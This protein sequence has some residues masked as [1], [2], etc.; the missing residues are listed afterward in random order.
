M[1]RARVSTLPDWR[2]MKFWEKRQKIRKSSK[3]FA[4]NIP[5]PFLL[6]TEQLRNLLPPGDGRQEPDRVRPDQ[7]L[8]RGDHGQLDARR[9]PVGLLLLVRV[10]DVG[11]VLGLVVAVVVLGGAVEARGLWGDVKG[12]R[13]VECKK[14]SLSQYSMY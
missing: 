6:P 12:S 13:L 9:L 10:R 7:P 14:V 2:T 4:T 11:R 8:Q 5:Y 3:V 1:D